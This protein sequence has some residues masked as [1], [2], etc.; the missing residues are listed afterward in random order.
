MATRTVN[1]EESRV[2]VHRRK[3]AQGEICAEGIYTIQLLTL[4]SCLST[5]G[6]RLSLWNGKVEP[7]RGAPWRRTLRLCQMGEKYFE[8]TLTKWLKRRGPHR[9]R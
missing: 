9:A 7:E 1:R 5:L 4:N 6:F 8:G 2:D 3:F